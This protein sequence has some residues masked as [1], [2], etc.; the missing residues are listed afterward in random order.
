[1]SASIINLIIQLIAGAGGSSIL[2]NAVNRFNLGPL[3]NIVTGLLGG[4]GGGNLLSALLHGGGTAAAANTGTGLD[5]GSVVTQ[6][7]GGG[8]GGPIVTIIVA[9]IRN[10]MSS[11]RSA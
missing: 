1:M 6:L 4:V 11:Q 3:G 10:A 8:V 7:I 5:L 9:L 2:A